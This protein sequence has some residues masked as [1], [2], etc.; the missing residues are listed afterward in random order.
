M[1]EYRC[2]CECAAAPLSWVRCLPQ[3]VSL[4]YDSI[5]YNTLVLPA[6]NIVKYN[7]LGGGPGAQLYGVEARA[8]AR[9]QF[10]GCAVGPV[11]SR[12]RVCS[13]GRFT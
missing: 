10:M 8:H 7:V 1:C 2:C 11:A 9:A 4:L 5:A 13:R 3:G 6:W 12:G